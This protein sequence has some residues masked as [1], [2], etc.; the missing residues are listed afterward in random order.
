MPSRLSV[1]TLLAVTLVAWS[2]DHWPEFRGPHGNGHADATNLPL[3]WL[4]DENV[5]W[6]TAVHDKGWSSPVIWGNQVWVTTA[7]EAGDKCY[8]I[9]I[10]RD[11][12]KVVH[13]LLLFEVRLAPR[14]GG[15]TPPSIMAPYEEWARFNSY[16]SPTPALEEGRV[17]VHFGATGTACLDT[18]TGKV[19][20]TRTNL[21]CGHHRGAGSSPILHGD[22]VILTF[23]GFDVQYLA[24]LDKK[25]GD[26]VWKR[27]RN[28]HEATKNGDLKKA[29]STPVVIAVNDRP[30]LVSQ[31]AEA[32]AAYDP[33]TGEEVWRVVHKGMNASQRPV[34]GDG[35]LFTSGSDGGRSL[36][37][38]RPDGK[39]NVT[40]SHVE[41]AHDK[42]AAPNRTSV[43]LVGDKLFM[44]NTGGIATCVDAKSGKEL[45]RVRL[46]SKGGQFW[47]S[48]IYADGKWYAFDDKGHGF[49]ISA[50]EKL[51][52]LATNKLATGG[53]PSPA[54][55]GNALYVRTETHLYR[56]EVK[57]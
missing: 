29:Y 19:L 22:L 11:S 31:S 17:Y 20:W 2:A 40:R 28:F 56:L 52:V 21:E 55:V 57:K 8:A 33:K 42:G 36:L 47:A 23:D 1:F 16:A 44:V 41:W 43:L 10:D 3:T 5:R 49:V 39:G 45:N 25:T 13:D 6:K 4:E 34:F 26:T 54:A 9:A 35:K 15:N 46:D 7:T 14:K 12:G 32:T 24:A 48:P 53:R 18:A 51:T 27:D 50:D 37:A 30:M 38:V